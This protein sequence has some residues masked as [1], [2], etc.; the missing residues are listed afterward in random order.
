[1][2]SSPYRFT[3]IRQF[4]I[5]EVNETASPAVTPT[6]TILVPLGYC[7]AIFSPLGRAERFCA[8]TESDAV[9]V[10]PPGQV[11]DKVMVAVP[12]RVMA[13]KDVVVAEQMT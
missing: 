8:N 7:Q 6:V 4:T 12:P 2:A 13:G 1:M 10:C 3:T 11:A 9:K 5:D